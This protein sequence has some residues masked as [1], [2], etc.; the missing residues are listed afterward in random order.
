VIYKEASAS[1]SNHKE[2][3]YEVT[4]FSRVHNREGALCPFFISHHPERNRVTAPVSALATEPTGDIGTTGGRPGTEQ[5]ESLPLLS[6]GR[7]A[8]WPL[9]MLR[10]INMEAIMGTVYNDLDKQLLAAFTAANNSYRRA[11]TD[12]ELIRTMAEMWV[13]AGG[14]AGGFD[15]YYVAKLRAEIEQVERDCV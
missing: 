12:A 14:E 4:R 9:P 10:T 5:P 7:E 15:D 13:Q 1:K 6:P 3:A 2:V 8:S 11:L